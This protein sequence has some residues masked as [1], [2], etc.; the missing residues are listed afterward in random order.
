MGST[1]KPKLT[2]QQQI[3]RL[4]G[5]GV[6]F[7]IISKNDAVEYLTRNNNYFKLT[8][9]RKTFKKHLGDEN[10][11]KYIGLDFAHLKD[12]SIIDMR[13][14]YALLHL[15]LDIEH[16]AKVKLIKN[17]TESEDDGYCAVKGFIESLGEQQRAAFDKEIERNRDN[18]YCGAIIQK[19]DGDYPIWAFVEI[20][21][22][23]RFVAFYRYCISD[24]LK[25]PALVDDY[26]LLLSVKGL[27]NAAAHSNCIINDLSPRTSTRR[28]NNAVIDAVSKIPGVSKEVRRKKLSNAR[29][30]Q[31]VT[32][33]YSH[34]KFV[35]SEGVHNHQSEV[36]HD[37]VERMF[38]HIDY[39]ATN[40][41]ITTTFNFIKL[42][43][44][45]WFPLA[46]NCGTK[47]K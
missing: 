22:F 47:K 21:P 5:K 9:Y 36:L 26:Y 10:K 4:A 2:E 37:V 42:V 25:D 6:Q 3:E 29:I 7:E 24:Y 43:V 15:A 20:I 19:Y 14:R 33:L 17:I 23:G 12:L 39:Y 35:T 30:Q 38:H 8:A 44:D 11:G 18:P 46:Y 13:L 16:Y 45:N 41:T 34:K 32:L 40:D 27:R 31:I 1:E 28:T